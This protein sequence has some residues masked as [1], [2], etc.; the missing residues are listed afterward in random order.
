[1][2]AKMVL[3]SLAPQAFSGHCQQLP[4]MQVN[5]SIGM[6]PSQSRSSA[7]LNNL[8]AVTISRRPFEALTC[9]DGRTHGK[10]PPQTAA[11]WC[12]LDRQT[13]RHQVSLAYSSGKIGA[14]LGL[15]F[16]S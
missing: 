15:F 4:A 5:T 16:C 6:L 10:Q 1:M 9:T 2:G 14:T 7:T 3:N 12:R 11:F 8:G 13:A